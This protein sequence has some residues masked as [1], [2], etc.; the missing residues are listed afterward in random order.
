M[1]LQA[2]QVGEICG[3]GDKE[4]G[5]VTL[6]CKL[7]AYK[8]LTACRGAFLLRGYGVPPENG[9]AMMVAGQFA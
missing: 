7:L 5:S 8:D 4:G 6:A 1:C 2:D 3:D 9:V